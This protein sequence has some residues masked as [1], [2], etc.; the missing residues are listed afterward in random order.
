MCCVGGHNI[1]KLILNIFPYC[2]LLAGLLLG[3]ILNPESGG[4]IFLQNVG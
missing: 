1:D 4:A 3:L 2:L